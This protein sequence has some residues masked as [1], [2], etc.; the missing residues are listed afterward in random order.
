[1][2]LAVGV[3]WSAGEY[4]HLNASFQNRGKRMDE[5]VQVL[6]TLWRGGKII[7]YHGQYY[8]FER[9]VFSPPPLQPGGPPLW[10]A[11][12]SPRALQRAVRLADGWHPNAMPPE[13]LNERLTA[14]RP[15]LMR[16]PFTV[17]MRIRLAADAA[18]SAET[19]SGSPEQIIARLLAYQAAGLNYAVIQFQAASQ[20]E[21]ERA[22]QTF[23]RQVLPVFR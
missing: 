23:A 20:P 7:S 16:R 8:N 14:V 10:V 6:R 1:M 22:M 4:A 15:L 3:G 11:G 18:P 17:A 21:R 19:L 9:L 12:D 2:M 13:T 5:A